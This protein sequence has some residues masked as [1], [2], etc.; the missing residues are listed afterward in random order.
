[1]MRKSTLS[2]MDITFEANTHELDGS[3]YDNGSYCSDKGAAAGYG[4]MVGLDK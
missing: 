1:M 4:Q 3:A 2:V